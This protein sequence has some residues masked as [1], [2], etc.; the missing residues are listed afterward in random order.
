MPS[1]YLPANGDDLLLALAQRLLQS[2]R[3]VD[4]LPAGHQEAAAGAYRGRAHDC[5]ALAYLACD[6]LCCQDCRS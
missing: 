2:K 3:G 1:I 4:V 6:V 5:E